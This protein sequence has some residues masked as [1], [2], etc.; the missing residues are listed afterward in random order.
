M[1]LLDKIKELLKEK[2]KLLDKIKELLKE[3]LKGIRNKKNFFYLN[4]GCYEENGVYQADINNM[5]E[6]Y[7]KQFKQQKEYEK[8]G[9]KNWQDCVIYDFKKSLGEEEKKK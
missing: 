2:M 4:K 5:V 8:A 1:K 3:F 9:L 7:F 6:N